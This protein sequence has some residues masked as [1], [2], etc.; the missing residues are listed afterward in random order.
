M[1]GKMLA[2][3]NAPVFLRLMMPEGGALWFY[4]A[5]HRVSE[6]VEG[7]LHCGDMNNWP[8]RKTPLALC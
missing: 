4:D 5:N 7:G 3:D 1:T 8:E 2:V 6:Q